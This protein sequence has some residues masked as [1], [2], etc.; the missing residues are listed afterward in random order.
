MAILKALE[1]VLIMC[2]DKNLLLEI[3]AVVQ[4]VK[5]PAAAAWVTF[6]LYT[7]G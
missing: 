6:E 3:P 2:I 4:W 7:V 5:I 1:T